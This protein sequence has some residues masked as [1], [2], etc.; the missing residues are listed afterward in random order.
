MKTKVKPPNSQGQ[1]PKAAA[2]TYR[3][4]IAEAVHLTM[5]GFHEAG[6]IDDNT[7]RDFDEGCLTPVIHFTP[8]QIKRLRK[9]EGVSQTVF[10]RY[11]NVSSTIISQWE[12]GLKKPGPTAAKLLSL[13]EKNGLESI[14]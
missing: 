5:Q 13:V 8:T 11:L 2:K 3:S 9:K 1:S 14:A 4:P 7:M 10:A 6:I 12:R